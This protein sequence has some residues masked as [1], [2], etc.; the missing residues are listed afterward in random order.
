MTVQE[1]IDAYLKLGEQVFQ[2]Q[3]SSLFAIATS[4]LT[5]TT[6]A[7]KFD[8]EKLER[9]IKDMVTRRS[10]PEYSLL[11]DSPDAMCKVQ[12]CFTTLIDTLLISNF[13]TCGGDN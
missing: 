6:I 5:Q 11:K 7:G 3:R 9:A 10:L 8:A 4:V 13:Q 2:P 12:V 1:C